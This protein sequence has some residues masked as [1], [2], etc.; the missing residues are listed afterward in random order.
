MIVIVG[1]SSCLPYLLCLSDSGSHCSLFICYL[2]YFHQPY[3]LQS[4]RLLPLGFRQLIYFDIVINT[5]TAEY[6]K[7][8]R[9]VLD[10]I[11]WCRIFCFYPF[12]N[13]HYLQWQLL[14]IE[15]CGESPF[16]IGHH[17]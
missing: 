4:S 2:S 6:S 11:Q 1:A 17:N 13:G 5:G 16:K 9:F 3:S 7:A 12:S 14:E 10:E 8:L 15:Y